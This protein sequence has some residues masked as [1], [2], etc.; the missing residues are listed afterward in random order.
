VNSSELGNEYSGVGKG[1]KLYDQLN[2]QH[3]LKKDVSAYSYLAWLVILFVDRQK[4]SGG[5]KSTTFIVTCGTNTNGIFQCN[6]FDSGNSVNV[7]TVE[8]DCNVVST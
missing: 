6:H 7:R 4:L 1:M 3:L 5:R 2:C 8:R